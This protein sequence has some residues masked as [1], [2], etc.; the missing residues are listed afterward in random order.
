MKLFWTRK[1]VGIVKQALQCTPQCRSVSGWPK[2]ARSQDFTLEVQKLRGCTFFLKKV[3]DFFSHHP[4]NS[5][6]LNNG[7]HSWHIW[8]AT[9]QRPVFS[10]KNPLSQQLGYMAMPLDPRIPGRAFWRKNVDSGL[11][12]SRKMKAVTRDRADVY[13]RVK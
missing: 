4:Q 6:S 3:D 9:S 2:Q 13:S 8:G 7:V 10:F 5:S 11:L 1:D 12:C